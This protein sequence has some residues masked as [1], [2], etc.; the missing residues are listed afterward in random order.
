VIL[1]IAS[2]M[3]FLLPTA[4]FLG[5]W[6]TLFADPWIRGAALV[7]CGAV[8]G[9][10]LPPRLGNRLWRAVLGILATGALFSAILPCV[11]IRQY[12]FSLTWSEG[13]HIWAA[14][15]FFRLGDYPGFAPDLWP[16]YA[17]TGLYA[18][19]GLPFLFGRS[20]IAVLR[21]WDALLDVLPPFGVGSA[22][23]LWQE[24]WG[25]WA[26]RGSLALG[27]ALL[28]AQAHD[29][30]PIG[31]A[32]IA[33]ALA[34]RGGRWRLILLA[35]LVTSFLVGI[36]R[37]TW[38]AA[39]PVW[40]GTW[41]LLTP[42]VPAA[43]RWRKAAVAGAAGAAGIGFSFAWK[44]WVERRPLLLYLTDLRHPMLWYRLLPN[45]TSHLGILPWILI[46]GLPPG[47]VIAW[48]LLRGEPAWRWWR[49]LAV[50]VGALG[51][52]VIG[53]LASVKMGGGDNLHHF[54][55]LLIYIALIAGALGSGSRSDDRLFTEDRP[56]TPVLAVV[57][58][59]PIAWVASLAA[60][61]S[62][63][64]EGV[65]E[66]ALRTVQDTMINA[67]S[68]GPVLLIDQRQLITFGLVPNVP[69]VW[70]YEQGE[71][72]DHAMARDE[73]YL[74]RFHSDLSAHRFSLIVSEPLHVVW[75]GDTYPFGEENDVWVESVAAPVLES[76]RP[77]AE[78]D[79]VGV[80]LLEPNAEVGTP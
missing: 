51:F 2:A 25:P 23:F 67:A 3:L 46:V 74:D 52:L 21:L 69:E 38:M 77:V 57:L 4:A 40:V 14:S 37:W 75:R 48:A 42:R 18:L 53:L 17:A 27:S 76:Y 39:P 78:L 45:A 70:D 16:H 66:A 32:A 10:L 60:P 54:D 5:P 68:R 26:V 19:Q 55:M 13:N 80:W 44:A 35:T 63:L 11:S 72:V 56:A 9:E 64:S 20:S 29:Y 22:I 1:G 34:L 41:M 15:L 65:A 62:L 58:L 79:E 36:S 73:A 28:I 7:A 61:P 31:L 12:P 33:I 50:G 59:L 8:G 47:L 71:L 49:L 24:A 43:E 6:R 30:A